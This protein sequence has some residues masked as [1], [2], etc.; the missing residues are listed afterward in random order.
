MKVSELKS[1]GFTLLE[2]C[3][4][5]TIVGVLCAVA[6]PSYQSVFIKARISSAVS[7][8][9]AALLLA[10]SEALKRG[11]NVM[12]CRSSTTMS[13]NPRCD[14]NGGALPGDWGVGWLIYQDRDNNRQFGV[15]D[16]LIHT[17][18]RVFDSSN[19][20]SILSSPHRNQI[21]FSSTGQIFGNY[22]SFH[23]QRPAYDPNGE[24]DRYV[25]VAS[26]G[27]ARVATSICAR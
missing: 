24:H 17:H 16:E 9:H 22:M 8:F 14:V 7:E 4:V 1:Y 15:G 18:A 23:I 11:D 3:I 13:E 27:R 26:G 20:G 2:S 6:L 5:I 19:D 21:H 12:M 10:R 25:C